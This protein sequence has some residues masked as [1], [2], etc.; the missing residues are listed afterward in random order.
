MKILVTGF[1]PFGGESVN[2]AWLAVQALPDVIGPWQVHKAEVPT[3]FDASRVCLTK[4]VE[5]LRPDAVIC[6]G[7]AGGR[8]AITIERVAINVMDAALPDNEGDQPQD[9]PV[10]S[11]APAA[12]F[13][14]L[15]IKAM[16]AAIQAASLPAKV[17]NTA[18]TFVCNTLMY[19]LLHL[20]AT[21]Y[22]AMMGGFIHVPYVPEQV[23]NKPAGTPCMAAADI[24]RALE[25]A[26]QAI[27]APQ[28]EG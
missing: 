6:V 24:T 22:P 25:A 4:L 8:D 10:V 5:T 20:A 27:P 17:S 9:V 16:V 23:T 15:P 12:Y 21:K 7:Q 28:K 26:I 1:T 18:G 14:T 13:T 19:H 2:P 3:A 11:G